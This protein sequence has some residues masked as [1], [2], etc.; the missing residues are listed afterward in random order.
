[1]TDNRTSRSSRS[2]A[3]LLS[4]SLT[5][6]QQDH[7]GKLIA[8]SPNVGAPTVASWATPMTPTMMDTFV[9]TAGNKLTGVNA[10]QTVAIDTLVQRSDA[11]GT[12]STAAAWTGYATTGDNAFDNVPVTT[13][14]ESGNAGVLAEIEGNT[15][16]NEIGFCDLGYVLTSTGSLQSTASNV[17]IVPVTDAASDVF[18]PAA[19]TGASL[20]AATLQSAKDLFTSTPQAAGANYPQKLDSG[21][22]YVTNGAPSTLVQ[23]FITFVQSPNGGTDMQTAGDYSLLEVKS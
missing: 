2:V 19:A 12:E 8:Q 22:Y 1:M 9:S 5:T 10:A 13:K 4:G 6:Q 11:S 14:A 7:L 15:P 23:N 18:A 16:G 17:V 3:G 21:L 20:R